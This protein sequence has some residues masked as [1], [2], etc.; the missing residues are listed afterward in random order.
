[1][2]RDKYDRMKRWQTHL[3]GERQ[4][5]DRLID[6]LY[7]FFECCYHLK[8][9]LRGDPAVDPRIGR[10]AET[11]IGARRT[12]MIAADLANGS[13]HL[14]RTRPARI[15]PNARVARVEGAFQRGAFQENTFQ[16][17]RVVVVV[18]G[19]RHNA[20]DVVNESV[21]DWETFLRTNGLL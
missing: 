21:A 6:D 12:L 18:D 13:K 5:D 19:E 10:D 17:E 4:I 16:V 2:W 15:D 9:W 1:M 3:A 8:D 20:L 14:V 11:Y 7:A